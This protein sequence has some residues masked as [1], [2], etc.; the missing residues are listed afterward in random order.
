[1]GERRAAAGAPVCGVDGGRT[2][3]S[4]GV[5]PRPQAKPI[6][7]IPDDIWAHAR[8]AIFPPESFAAAAG[9]VAAVLDLADLAGRTLD[10]LDLPCGPGR[11]TMAF[12]EAGH[13]VV[14]VDSAL[15]YLHELRSRLATR[16]ARE[17]DVD[18]EVVSGDMRT[19]WRSG[20]FDLAVNLYHSFGYFADPEEDRAT[21]RCYAA[22]LRPGGK[23]VLELLGL[24]NLAKR[25]RP[26]DWHRMPDGSLHLQERRVRDDWGWLDV[27]WIFV[28]DGVE[29]SFSFGHRLYSGRDL[30]RELL[31][32]GFS[33]VQ[34][35]GGFGG[36]PYDADAERLVAVATK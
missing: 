19:F 7:M 6:P 36:G 20:A 15:S 9:E 34:L 14:A 31:A 8:D 13:R 2:A 32:A 10:V 22:S 3:A 27:D 25:F 24:E 26:R 23:L 30:R 18:V 33:D 16:R 28:E 21:L 35:F 17:G 5:A 12:A 1:V 4:P 11:H 29:R